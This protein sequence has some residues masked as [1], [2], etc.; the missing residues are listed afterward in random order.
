MAEKVVRKELCKE[1]CELRKELSLVRKLLEHGTDADLASA[2][3]ELDSVLYTRL[4]E[5]ESLL[6]PTSRER[7]LKTLK[8]ADGSVVLTADVWEDVMAR[9]TVEEIMAKYEIKSIAT[10]YKHVKASKGLR[11]ESLKK[12]KKDYEYGK[13]VLKLLKSSKERF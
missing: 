6:V 1:F 2:K 10:F 12:A 3:S 11:G 4:D 5:I 7:A 13:T 9:L 8:K